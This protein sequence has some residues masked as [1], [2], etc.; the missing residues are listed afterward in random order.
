MSTFAAR[1]PTLVYLLVKGIDRDVAGQFLAGRARKNVALTAILFAMYFARRA[2]VRQVRARCARQSG[3][4]YLRRDLSS[5][6]N[7]APANEPVEPGIGH[8]D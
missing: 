2:F 6:L 7:S 3:S 5:S 8:G 4:R 1:R